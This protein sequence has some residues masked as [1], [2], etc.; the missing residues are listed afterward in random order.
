MPQ[1]ALKGYLYE[2][3]G[4]KWLPKGET[5]DKPKVCPKYKSAYRNMPRRLDV[6]KKQLDMDFK[7]KRRLR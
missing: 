5:K 1:I 4:H 6:V 3:C 7:G 2:R